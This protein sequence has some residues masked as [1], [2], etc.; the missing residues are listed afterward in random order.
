VAGAA[1]IGAGNAHVNAKAVTTCPAAPI[2]ARR[3]S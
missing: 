1:I 2:E 3:L